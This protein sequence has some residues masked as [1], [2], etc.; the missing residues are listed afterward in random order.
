MQ[1][2]MQLPCFSSNPSN[3][4]LETSKAPSS[5]QWKLSF[6]LSTSEPVNDRTALLIESFWA[7]KLPSIFPEYLNSRFHSPHILNISNDRP[8]S[9]SFKA[10]TAEHSAWKMRGHFYRVALQRNGIDNSPSLPSLTKALQ[11][12]LLKYFNPCLSQN[13]VG[14][15]F[16]VQ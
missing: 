9:Q 12:C 5:V 4:E 1:R 15:I 6:K 14:R 10:R 16:V 8:A 7:F 13:S 2:K 11:N 3:F